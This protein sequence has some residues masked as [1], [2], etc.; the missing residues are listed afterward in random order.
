MDFELLIMEQLGGC[1]ILEQ[2]LDKHLEADLRDANIFTWIDPASMVESHGNFLT[3]RTEN[4]FEDIYNIE[5][6]LQ[7]KALPDSY[8]FNLF[9][10][11]LEQILQ[12]IHQCINYN[13]SM[14]AS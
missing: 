2:F 14:P 13:L 11:E 12:V 7:S 8:K 6:D 1:E 4:E 9:F 10:N 5:V 3:A